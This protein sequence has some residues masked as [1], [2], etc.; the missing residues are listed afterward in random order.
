M[1]NS[2]YASPTALKFGIAGL[3]SHFTQTYERKFPYRIEEKFGKF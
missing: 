3:Y 1:C 2:G